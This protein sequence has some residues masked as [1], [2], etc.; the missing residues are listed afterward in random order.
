MVNGSPAVISGLSTTDSNFGFTA[1]ELGNIE[2]LASVSPRKPVLERKLGLVVMSV[3]QKAKPRVDKLVRKF[4][5]AKFSFMLFHWDNATW[6]EFSW[7]KDIVSARAIGQ[8][9]FWFAK[10]FLTP[11]IVQAYD[12]IWLWDDDVELEENFDPLGFTDVLKQYNIHIAQPSLLAGDHH[13]VTRQQ[14]AGIGRFTNFVEIMFP[15]FSSSAWM[16]VWSLI[17]FD[18]KSAWGVDGVS[19]PACG[20]MG[21]CRFA[22][23]DK[24]PVRHMD[25]KSFTGNF[26]ANG[27]EGKVYKYMMS[28]KCRDIDSLRAPRHLQLFCRLW[29]MRDPMITAYATIR[30]IDSRDKVT[31]SC[32]NPD[33]FPGLENIAV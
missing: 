8:T 33:D 15:I 29:G 9:K 7:Y 13:V 20:S 28:T 10:R 32:P 3:G 18:V 25:T 1:R 22:I 23:I 2:R 16:C 5:T 19:Y 24:Y 11:D 14:T 27:D 4:G 31:Q 17:P 12:Y 21:F 30:A 6:D 26:A